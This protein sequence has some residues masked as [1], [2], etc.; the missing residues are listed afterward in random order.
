MNEEINLKNNVI[1]HMAYN[2]IAF[3]IILSIF[4]GFMFLIIK[5]VTY[6]RVDEELYIARD[7]ILEWDMMNSEFYYDIFK[8]FVDS[9]KLNTDDMDML[10]YFVFL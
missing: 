4:A 5:T 9:Y 1:K 10:N 6:A 2:I 3:A 8:S 7:E